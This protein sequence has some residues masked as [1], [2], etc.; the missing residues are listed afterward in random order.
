MPDQNA[1]SSML[2]G[3][4]VKVEEHLVASV[5]QEIWSSMLGMD[6]E[7]GHPPGDRGCATLS[8]SVQFGGAWHG[9]V[10]LNCPGN[11]ARTLAAGMF[12]TEPELLSREDIFDAVGELANVIGGNIK[13]LL[14]P[15][16][17]LRLP[18]V[19]EQA[20][21]DRTTESGS[22]VTEVV[23]RCESETFRVALVESHAVDA[24]NTPL[25]AEHASLNCG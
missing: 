23:F 3:S 18:T 24:S 9:A 12:G 5:V 13:H 8:G 10:F 2:P 17:Q 22:L 21:P 1:E 11:L 15:P 20:E 14:P 7:A 4:A 16:C 6:A 19:Q 25:G